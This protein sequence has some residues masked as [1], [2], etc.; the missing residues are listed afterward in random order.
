[1]V[2]G[3]GDSEVRL[4]EVI[5]VLRS[6]GIKR[7]WEVGNSLFGSDTRYCSNEGFGDN[8]VVYATFPRSGNS[9]VRKYLENITAIATGSDMVMRHVPNISLQI[10]GFKGEGIT[11]NRCWIKKSHFPLSLPF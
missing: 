2:N 6:R 8:S 10:A 11:D 4:S 5:E 3:G 7:Y 9:M 1:L